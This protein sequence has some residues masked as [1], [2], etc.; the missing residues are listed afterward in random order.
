MDRTCGV[1]LALC[2]L[3]LGV[4]TW[5]AV[6]TPRATVSI[7]QHAVGIPRAQPARVNGVSDPAVTFFVTR[8]ATPAR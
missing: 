2:A 8:T 5:A 6:R 7:T 3:G 1:A 4:A